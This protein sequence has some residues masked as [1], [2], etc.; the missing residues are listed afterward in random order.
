LRLEQESGSALQDPR[1]GNRAELRVRLDPF[2]FID[3]LDVTANLNSG[4]ENNEAGKMTEGVSRL[5][6][7]EN[8]RLRLGVSRRRNRAMGWGAGSLRGWFQSAPGGEAGGN[9]LAQTCL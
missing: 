1:N 9:A 4:D 5:A 2:G 6:A 7:S 8:A 3:R